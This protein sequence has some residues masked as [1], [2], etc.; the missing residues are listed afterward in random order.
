M[1]RVA[2]SILY[3]WHKHIYTRK[4]FSI[5]LILGNKATFDIEKVSELN[6][7]ICAMAANPPVAIEALL[8]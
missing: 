2:I 5:D 8:G 1:F 4:R 6:S 3:L 7:Q